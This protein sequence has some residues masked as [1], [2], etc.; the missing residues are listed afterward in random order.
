MEKK[1]TN[2]SQT[3]NTQHKTAFRRRNKNKDSDHKH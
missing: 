3:D 1:I 2:G